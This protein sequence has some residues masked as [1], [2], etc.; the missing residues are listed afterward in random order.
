MAT[1]A[2]KAKLRVTLNRFCGVAKASVANDR[3]T[4]ASSAAAST[5]NACRLNTRATRPWLR[6]SMARCRSLEI[7]SFIVASAAGDRAGDEPRALFGAG[8]GHRLV[9]DLG[10][11]AQHDDAIGHREHIRHAVADEH[12]GDALLS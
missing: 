3:I 7:E 10:A 5:Q 9:G 4:A 1:M 12:D 6:V 8:G 2:T 11:A